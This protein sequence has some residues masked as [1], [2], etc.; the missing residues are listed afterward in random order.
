MARKRK[1]IVWIFSMILIITIL[2]IAFGERIVNY[3]FDKKFHPREPKNE[4]DVT[5]NVGWWAYQNSMQIDS[6]K[7]ELIDSRLN[8]FN[9]FSL[10]RYTIYGELSK[11]GNWRPYIDKVH[12]S[13]R[14][15]RKYDRDLHPYLDGDT[16][17]IPEAIIEITPIVKV[18]ADNVYKGER[19]P[20]KITNELKIGSF[21]WGNNWLRLQCDTIK[22]DI[23]LRQ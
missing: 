15:I 11:N 6:F 10:I 13:E 22:R 1:I 12:I 18:K 19:I 17:N 4:I 3:Y 21:H 8:L 14:F 5:Y 20:F 2:I 23:I 16:V 7:V 9:S